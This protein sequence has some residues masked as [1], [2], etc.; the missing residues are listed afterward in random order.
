M[1][2]TGISAI[3][4]VALFAGFS[5]GFAI[6]ETSRED[7]R[8]T[9]ILLQKT[10]MIRLLTWSQLTNC[11]TTFQESYYDA[12]SNENSGILYYG[13]LSTL[14]DPT[15]IPSTVTYRSQ[16]HLIT[17]S[18]VWTNSIGNFTRVH[19]R[20]IQTLSAKNGMQQY[21]YGLTQ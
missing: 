13:T 21:L 3:A 5:S 10:E 16:V 4:L 15:N 17:I 6:L 1:V 14:G 2:A 9:Q 19:S 7:V 18:L 12:G 11:P 8:A 20:Q